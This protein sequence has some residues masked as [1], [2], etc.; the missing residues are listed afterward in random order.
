MDLPTRTARSRSIATTLPAVLVV[1]DP[2]SDPPRVGVGEGDPDGG[3]YEVVLASRPSANVLV[4]VTASD[5]GRVAAGSVMADVSAVLTFTDQDWSV[6]QTVTVTAVADFDAV[7]DEATVTHAVSSGDG[8]YDQI[9][10]EDVAVVVVDDDAAGVSVVTDPVSDPPRLSVAE[11][12]RASYSVV[13]DSEPVGEVAVAVAAGAA[14]TVAPEVLDFDVTNWD[15]AQVVVVVPNPDAGTD[16]ASATVSHSVSGSALEYVG[17]EV[18]SVVVDIDDGL[19]AAAAVSVAPRHLA[20][21]EGETTIRSYEVVLATRPA[22]DVTVTPAAPDAAPAGVSVSVSGALVFTSGNWFEPQTV[23]VTVTAA[24]DVDADHELLAV[25]HAVVSGDGDYDEIAAAAVSVFVVDDEAAAAVVVAPTVLGVGE[26]DP[27][28]GTY[29]VRLNT[30]PAAAVT[31]TVSGQ[32]QSDLSVAG[33]DGGASVEFGAG[34]WFVARAFTVTAASD[35]DAVDDVVV[36]AHAASSGDGDYEAIG[37]DSVTVTVDD[38]DT[39]AV[40]VV[41]DPV[42]DPPRLRVGEGDPDGGTYEVVLASRPSANVLVTVT[43]SD[44]VRVAAGSVMAAVVGWC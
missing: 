23:S 5:D 28:G 16:D 1:T 29:R 18:A 19:D 44:D 32:D 39:A 17:V 20:V 36:L 43:A 42:S 38:D 34:D 27:E 12:Q 15:V 21:P 3:T 14:V 41:T 33:P 9:G 6:P 26:A 24:S 10:V 25:T 11:G 35:D 22:Q 8:D 37:V 13:L 4:T 2:V 30:E 31:V 7:D 40:L